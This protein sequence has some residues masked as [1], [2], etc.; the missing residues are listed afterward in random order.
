MKRGPKQGPYPAWEIMQY[1][2]AAVN[3]LHQTMPAED[4]RRKAIR[5]SIQLLQFVLENDE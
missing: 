5:A 1:Y 2:T 3:E 4:F